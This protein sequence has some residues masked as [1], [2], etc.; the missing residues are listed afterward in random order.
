MRDSN[1]GQWIARLS[2]LSKE[3]FWRLYNAV[4]EE[5]ALRARIKAMKVHRRAET[6]G[7]L[8]RAVA[9]KLQLKLYGGRAPNQITCKKCLRIESRKDET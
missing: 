5:R 1:V 7:A 8:C 3:E 9:R 6:G 4:D 2:T